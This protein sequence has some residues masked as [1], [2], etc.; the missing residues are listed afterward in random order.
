VKSPQ[1]NRALS[2][3]ESLQLSK[4]AFKLSK[5]AFKLSKEA[6]SQ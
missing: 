2:Q 5:E 1:P 4:E 6:F 3:V